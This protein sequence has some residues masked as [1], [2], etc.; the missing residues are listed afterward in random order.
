MDVTLAAGFARRDYTAAVSWLPAEAIYWIDSKRF[1]K[2]L[3]EC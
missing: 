1:G 3:L 2:V